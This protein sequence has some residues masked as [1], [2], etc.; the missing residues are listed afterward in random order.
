MG[1][2]GNFFY[3]SLLTLSSYIAGLVTF[4]Y[5]S[6]VLGA[7]NIGTVSFVDSTINYFIIF[8]TLGI[9]IIGVREIA[10]YRNDREKMNIAF[11]GLV[12]MCMIF[13]AVVMAVYIAAFLLIPKFNAQRELF[14]IGAAKLLFSAFLI[15]WFY[16]GIEN[17][18][19]IT[20]RTLAIK[21]VYI[22][23]L[24]VFVRSKTDYKIYFVLTVAVVVVN[25]L[26]NSAY[27]RNFVSFSFRGV[28][29]KP[30]FKQS[31][32]L[33]SYTVL[34]SMYTTFNVIFL[35]M[36]A[37]SEQVGYYWA[38][39]KIYGIFLGFFSALTAV[40]MPRMS[41]LLSEGR[42]EAFRQMILKSF[43]ALFTVCFPLMIGAIVLAP[44]IIKL[45]S[46]DGFTGAVVPMQII[47]P[48]VLVV[49]IA[50]ILAIQVLMPMKKDRA[51]LIASLIGAGMGVLLNFILVGRY[52]STGSAVVLLV[53]E[54]AV[55]VW[56][57]FIAIKNDII[58]FPWKTL[59]LN[60]LYSIPYLLLCYGS[61]LLFKNTI[62]AL[63]AAGFS[64]AI[65]FI[66]IQKYILKNTDLLGVLKAIG[67]RIGGGKIINDTD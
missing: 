21:L 56:Y 59:Q 9:G 4:P 43:D 33:G 2:K 1:I 17:F 45:L 40:M 32:V 6:R 55:T 5:V 23:S 22:L 3:N 16:R 7:S 50:Q 46:G 51:I 14:F 60:L 12:T 8:S 11:S 62:P 53:S 37:N 66:M 54:T 30:Y 52:G 63:L 35:G 38:A 67:A 44:Q 27:A 31:F 41:S 65:Y 36:N 47:M 29:L 26:I 58:D 28:A 19:Y 48:L 64:S 20:I 42:E 24:F 10:R 34:T 39:L 13:T 61:T 49:G 15:E 18:K 25:S 57:L